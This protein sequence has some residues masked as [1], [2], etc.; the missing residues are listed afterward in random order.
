MNADDPDIIGGKLNCPRLGKTRKTPFGG[1]VVRKP[2]AAPKTHDGGIVND[3]AFF[4]FHHD[5]CDTSCDVERPFE[6]DV[7][8]RIPF[9]V[10]HLVNRCI[11]ADAGVVEENV[12]RA[13][14]FDCLVNGGGN[15]FVVPDVTD[16]GN[17]LASQVLNFFYE[18]FKLIVCAEFIL[19]I[20]NFFCYIKSDDF[21]AFC[22]KAQRDRTSLTV[23]GAGDKSNLVVKISHFRF[24]PLWFSACN[25]TV[26]RQAA[27]WQSC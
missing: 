13:E 27:L 10:R 18:R 4:G 15:G 20:F 24:P 19:R 5:R 8:H 9:L 6:V 12:N 22:G 14:C 17:R 23:S 7:N 11:S 16:A 21:C 25:Y 3:N 2:V 1:G 26:P